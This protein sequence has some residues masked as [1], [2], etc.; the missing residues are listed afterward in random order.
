MDI[1]LSAHGNAGVYY[2]EAKKALSKEQKTVDV[3]SHAIKQA[4]KKTRKDL[5]Q[6]KLKHA[7]QHIRK[8]LWFEKFNWFISQ[9]GYLVLAGRDMQQN[10][11][12]R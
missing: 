2:E 6:V 10:E 3:S 4:E 5:K 12:M 9:D 11:V 7:I 1:G 8:P